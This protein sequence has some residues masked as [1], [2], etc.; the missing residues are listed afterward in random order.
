MAQTHTTHPRKN[1]D[2]RIVTIQRPS[3][4]TPLSA[5]A[6]PT[7]LATVVPGGPVPAALNGVAFESWADVPASPQ[8][9]EAQLQDEIPEPAFN[10]PHGLEAAAG[11]VIQEPDGRIWF[12][13]PTNQFGGYTVTFPKGRQEAGVSLQATARI[14]AFEKS[15]LQVRLVRHLVDVS[16]TQTFTRYYLAERVGGTPSAMGWESQAVMLVS[17]AQLE[18][19][20]LKAPD[21]LVLAAL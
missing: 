10:P 20:K 5:W 3:Q 21:R 13:C 9:R 15:G 19:L 2:G 7:G 16:R 14:E 4:P 17:Q 6:D 11:V 1:D 8:G 18:G 12:V